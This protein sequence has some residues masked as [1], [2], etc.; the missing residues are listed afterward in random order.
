MTYHPGLGITWNDI[1]P[2]YDQ[3][4]YLRHLGMRES[5]RQVQDGVTVKGERSRPYPTHHEAG[6][7]HMLFAQAAKELGTNFRS[8]Q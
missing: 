8:R 4:E 5:Q 6:Y 3:F 2:H 1:E 7:G